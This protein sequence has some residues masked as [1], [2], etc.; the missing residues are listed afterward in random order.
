M[1]FDLFAN[2]PTQQ[3]LIYNFIK[4]KGRVRS[5]ELN[6]FGVLCHINNP[7]SRAREL[8]AKGLIWRVK[9]NVKICLYDGKCNEEIWSIYLADKEN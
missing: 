8:K 7:G 3:E 4:T 2:P 5:H 1:E 6:E 9:D